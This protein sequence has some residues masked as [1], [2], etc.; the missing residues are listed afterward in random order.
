MER[1]QEQA[2][3]PA[4]AA[5]TVHHRAPMQQQH[6]QQEHPPTVASPPQRA[7]AAAASPSAACHQGPKLKVVGLGGGGCSTVGRSA[8]LLSS[9]ADVLGGSVDLLMFNTD[10][11]AVDQH[12]HNL[13]S[14]PGLT[15]DAMTIGDELLAGRGAGGDPAAGRAAALADEEAI[16]HHLAGADMV[17]ITAGMGGGTGSGSAPV[18]ARIAQSMGALVVAVVS[19]PFGF[20]GGARAATASA[21]ID[22]LTPHADVL[23][24]VK[25]ERLLTTLPEDVSMVDAFE[26]ADGVAR[27]AIVGVSTLVG[28]NQLINVDLA[29]VRSVMHRAGRGL[30]SIGTASGEG[31]AQAAVAN[32]LT[33]PLLDVEK[34]SDVTGVAYSVLGGAALSLHEVGEIGETIKQVLDDDAQVIFGGGVDPELDPDE[35][36]VTLIATGFEPPPPT[37]EEIARAAAGRARRGGRAGA[38]GAAG[39]GQTLVYDVFA[40]HPPV[41]NLRAAEGGTALDDAMA[42]WEEYIDMRY[43]GI[44]VD[45]GE[46]GAGGSA[47]AAGDDA[48]AAAAAAAAFDSYEPVAGGSGMSGRAGATGASAEEVEAAA[49]AYLAAGRVMSAPKPRRGGASPWGI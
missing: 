35:I 43:N 9:M 33:S 25:N 19:S 22:A 38:A 30:I 46:A 15:F 12:R 17:F 20:E 27:Q 29:D 18:V 8:G 10:V 40:Y 34:L 42:R 47:D 49:D 45:G 11:Q 32:A 48:Y 4:P 7:A 39:G 21:A 14:L 37:P 2:T 16:R 36:V 41:R 44:R 6:E 5:T 1:Q 28:T 23:V 24:V 13:A 31:R 26:A 3:A